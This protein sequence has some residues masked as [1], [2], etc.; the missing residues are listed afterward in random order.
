MLW[1]GGHHG[2]C[3]ALPCQSLLMCHPQPALGDTGRPA[4]ALQ[5]WGWVV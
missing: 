5:M 1:A 2:R 4:G 3:P